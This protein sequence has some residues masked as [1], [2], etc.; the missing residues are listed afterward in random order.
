MKES[1]NRDGG[2]GREGEREKNKLIG[3]GL[4]GTGGVLC[5]TFLKKPWH[6]LQKSKD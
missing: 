6:S 4:L 5:G 3:A 2:G 1:R